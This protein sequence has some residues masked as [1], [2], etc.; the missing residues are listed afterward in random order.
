MII[1]TVT[2][3]TISFIAFPQR[4]GLSNYNKIYEFTTTVLGQQAHMVMTSVSGHLLNYEFATNFRNWS[5]CNPVAL[6]D[7]P[8]VKICPE[9]YQKI[10]RTLEREVRSCQGLIIWTDCDREGENIGYEVIKVCTDAKPNLEV[11]R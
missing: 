9:N 2:V 5:S 11:Y 8:V 4:E 3:V 10:K 6:F 7:A 1:I